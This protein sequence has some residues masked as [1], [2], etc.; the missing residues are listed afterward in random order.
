MHRSRTFSEGILGFVLHLSKLSDVLQVSD[1][2]RKMD[3]LLL[4]AYIWGM[5]VADDPL[6]HAVFI[7]GEAC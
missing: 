4:Q 2:P 7:V 1:K 3:V 5:A 6:I